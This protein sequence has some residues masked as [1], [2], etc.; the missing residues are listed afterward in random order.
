MGE[1]SDLKTREKVAEFN[2]GAGAEGKFPQ[3]KTFGEFSF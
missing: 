1:A 3:L 2:P